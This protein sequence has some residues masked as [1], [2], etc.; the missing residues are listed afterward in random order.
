VNTPLKLGVFAVALAGVFGAGAGLGAAV[1]PDR[2]DDDTDTV[3]PAGPTEGYRLRPAS[4]DLGEGTQ[5][6]RFQITDPSGLAVTDYEVE[7]EKELHLIVASSDL[8]SFEHVHPV[9]DASG[10]WSVELHGLEPG[11]YR[12]FADFAVK[13]GPALVLEHD[14]TVPGEPVVR[15]QPDPAPVTTVDGLDVE[16]VADGLAVGESRATLRVT[17]GG[18]P[19]VIEPY[20]GAGGHLVAISADDLDYLHVHPTGDDLDHGAVEFALAIPATGRY[21]LFFDFQ[22]DGAVRT[23]AF[24]VDVRDAGPGDAGGGEAPHEQEHG[25]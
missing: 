11:A 2:A 1:G 17:R 12:A 10:W 13:D 14:L 25:H 16:L 18:E 9:R 7:H 19:V 15:H 5:Q 4:P 23:A 24:T 21:R 6:F 20:L 22:V 3:A 8:V